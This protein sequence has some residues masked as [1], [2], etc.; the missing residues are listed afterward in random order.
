[1][2]TQ[3]A[4][5]VEALWD[6]LQGCRVVDLSVTLDD[7]L[8]CAWPGHVSFQHKVHNWYESVEQGPQR[9]RSRSAYYTCWITVDEHAGTHFDAPPHFIPPPQSGLPHANEWGAQHGDKVPLDELQGPAVVVDV[10]PLLSQGQPG[11]SP[12]IEPAFLAGWEERFG[13]FASGETVLLYTGWDRYHTREPEGRKY[14]DGPI[15]FGDE[16]GW[17]APSAEAVRYL[18]DRGIR[19]LGTDAP[20]IGA[21]HEG[22]SMHYAGLERGM[23][24]VESLARLDQLPVRGAYFIFMPLKVAHSSGACGRA[25]AFV[26]SGAE[27]VG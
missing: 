26:P 8:P 20:S 11:T 19:L 6:T 15:L 22:A 1:M 27:P 5:S 10:R 25:M 24:Y 12:L 14:V 23:R 18:Y 9:I 13:A 2:T 3:Q 17:P 21:A 4:P 16:P 7:A